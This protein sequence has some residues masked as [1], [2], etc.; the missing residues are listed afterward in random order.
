MHTPTGAPLTEGLLQPFVHG[1]GYQDFVPLPQPAAGANLAFTVESR[2]LIRVLGARC[3]VTTDANVANRFVSLDYINARGQTMM[4]NAVATV[5]VGSTTNL[6][7]EWNAQRADGAFVANCPVLAPVFPLFLSPGSQVQITVDS[8]Q[9]GDQI[10]LASLVIERF[11]SGAPGYKI[12][13][14]PDPDINLG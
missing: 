3:N 9:V 13:F 2:N 14:V 8:I 12:G 1:V 5:V 4:R 7:F 6:K 11:D 10:S